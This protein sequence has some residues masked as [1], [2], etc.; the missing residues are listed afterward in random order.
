MF[1]DMY[2]YDYLWYVDTRKLCKLRLLLN[3]SVICWEN[4]YINVEFIWNMCKYTNNV[5]VWSLDKC[6]AIDWMITCLI[7]KSIEMVST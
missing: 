3:S 2:I 1:H 6:Q 4:R 7:I 5:V